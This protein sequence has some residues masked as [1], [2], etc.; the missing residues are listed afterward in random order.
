MAQKVHCDRSERIAALV[1][2]VVEDGHSKHCME[3]MRGSCV[4]T[5]SKF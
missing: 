2:G 1:P 3:L 4:K 5:S